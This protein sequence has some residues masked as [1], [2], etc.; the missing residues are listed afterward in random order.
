M[1]TGVPLTPI[2]FFI[3]S[4]TKINYRMD[5]TGEKEKRTSKKNMD[6]GSKSSHDNK[7]CRTRSMEKQR[8]M[9]FGFR[10]TAT[11]VIKPD[12][13]TEHTLTCFDTTVSPSG[14][15]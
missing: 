5:T 11:A 14:S 15:L 9:A 8:G 4:F 10:K 12:R 7:K 2:I 13:E 6:G 3:C 1:M